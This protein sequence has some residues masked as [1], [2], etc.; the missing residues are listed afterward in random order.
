MQARQLKTT[1]AFA[2]AFVAAQAGAA[3]WSD[4][5]I[6]LTY[7]TQ[8]KEPGN[9]AEVKKAIATLQYVGGY[10]YGTNFFTL[11]MLK[12]S[13]ANPARG[14]A[15]GA[16]EVYVVY[17]NTVSFGKLGMGAKFG[18]VRD[19][20]FQAG[21]DFNSKNDAF[22]AGLIKV[23]AGPKV[24]FDVPG[25]LTLGLFYYKENNNNSISGKNVSFDATPRLGTVWSFNVPLGLPAQFKGF[26]NFTGSKGKDGFGGQTSPETWVDASLLWDLGSLA[27]KPKTFY[28]GL[29]YQYIHNKFGN[30]P[31]LAGTKVSAPSLQFQAHF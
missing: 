10:K 30:S 31:S 19:V 23:I 8:Y 17:N 29:G 9:A 24:E 6:G 26:A 21:F 1:L 7:G 4:A 25:L 18:P 15:R 20:G 12:S 22:G 13:D 11:D 27:G 2:L 3:D 28:G 14:S 16:Q 5:F